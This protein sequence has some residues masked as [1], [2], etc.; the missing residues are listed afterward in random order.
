MM[1]RILAIVLLLAAGFGAWRASD[2]LFD[3]TITPT[4]EPTMDTGG[5]LSAISAPVPT[6]RNLVTVTFETVNIHGL[7]TGATVAAGDV[8]AVR[9]ESSGWGVIVAPSDLAGGRIWRGCTNQSLSYGCFSG[10]TK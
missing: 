10:G 5:A 2:L 1:K 6:S 8:L 3:A 4:H 7:D 9:W